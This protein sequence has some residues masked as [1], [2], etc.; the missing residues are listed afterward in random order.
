GLGCSSLGGVLDRESESQS[1]RSV[2]MALDRGINFFDTAD[3][4]SM[5]RSEELLGQAVRGQRDRVIIATKGGSRFSPAWKTIVDSRSVL[6]PL[7]KVLKP[8][9]RYFNLVRHTQKRYDYSPGHLR[10][11]LETSLKRLDTVYID[12]YQIYNPTR[13]DLEA[14]AFIDTLERFKREGKIRYYGIE[15]HN[16]EDALQCPGVSAVQLA[17]SLADQ[18]AL[19]NVVPRLVE[20]GVGV[21]GCEPLAQGFLTTNTGRA[22]AEESARG[23]SQIRSR[24]QRASQFKFLIRPDRTLAQAAMQFAIRVPGISSVIPGMILPEQLEEN[25]GALTATPLTQDELQRIRD[26]GRAFT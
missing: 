26:S 16:A 10:R 4:Y 18:E 15:C 17:I 23:R 7:R 19:D 14:G 20:E 12:L 3:A 9:K 11:A 24:Q 21:I 6:V 22:L 25:M 8:F 1:L 13:A 5:G 2:R